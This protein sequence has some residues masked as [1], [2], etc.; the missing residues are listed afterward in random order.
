L[1]EESDTMDALCLDFLN[2]EFRDFRGR[3]V[4]DQLFEAG[5]LEQ[6]LI[7]WKLQP[8]DLADP[9]P[10]ADLLKL[11][12]LL[13][14]MV[15]ALASSHPTDSDLSELNTFLLAAPSSLQL[16]RR[17][18]RYQL[19]Q[20]PQWKDW[21]WIQAKIAASFAELLVTY[22]PRRLKVCENAHCR[23]IFY[24][25]SKSHTRRFCTSNKCANL[26]KMR[27]FRTRHKASFQGTDAEKT[28]KL[29]ALP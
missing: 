11:R 27:R 14:H 9:P 8:A 16:V 4:K 25:E 7:R 21:K 10:L 6:F 24:D 23:G 22:E 17:D 28:G 18:T 19:E 20:V 26:M 29:Q 3:W 1:E 5:W 12:A 2:S 13:R 15:E